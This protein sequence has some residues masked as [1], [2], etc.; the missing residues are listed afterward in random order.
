MLEGAGWNQG[1]AAAGMTEFP[2]GRVVFV[3]W[4]TSRLPVA[5]SS[6]NSFF[7]NPAELFD[8]QGTV[9]NA[10]A[11]LPRGTVHNRWSSNNATARSP[12]CRRSSA[13]VAAG[14][15]KP[16]PRGAI[17]SDWNARGLRGR[18]ET[19]SAC[20]P[21]AGGRYHARGRDGG[22]P[23]DQALVRRKIAAPC[24][25]RAKLNTGAGFGR[26]LKFQYE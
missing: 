16:P 22:A 3:P 26:T 25:A 18:P 8:V 13:A 2:A 19:G 4:A 5:R 7:K 20:R 23:M 11:L 15:N 12:Q 10:F 21:P 1:R 14:S 24:F 6:R 17:D 9:M